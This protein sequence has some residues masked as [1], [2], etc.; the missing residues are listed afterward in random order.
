MSQSGSK[1]GDVDCDGDGGDDD[2]GGRIFSG[3]P[4][5]IPNTLRDNICRKGIPSLRPIDPRKVHRGYIGGL[6]PNMW[7][8]IGNITPDIWE[9]TGN[10]LKYM[11]MWKTVYLDG[12]CVL[13]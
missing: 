5:P 10:I 9:Y 8:Y 1:V 2:G 11:E 12:L 6:T 4:G 3:H 13:D 7:E